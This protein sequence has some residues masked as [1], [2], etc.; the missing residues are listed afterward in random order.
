M[1]LASP[2]VFNTQMPYQFKSTSYQVSPCRADVGCAWWLLCQPSPNVKSATSQ[3]LVERSRVEKRR[4]PHICVTEFTAQVAC[5]PT[6]VRRKIPHNMSGN[7]PIASRIT[8]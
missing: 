7:P 5:S 1:S 8:P 4:E 3:L 2:S 6:T